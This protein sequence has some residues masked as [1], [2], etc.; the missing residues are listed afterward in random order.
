MQCFLKHVRIMAPDDVS[1]SSRQVL[2]VSAFVDIPEDT[3]GHAGI[4]FLI[5]VCHRTGFDKIYQ[6]IY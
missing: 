2:Y 5:I 6:T 4:L 1:K 3:N